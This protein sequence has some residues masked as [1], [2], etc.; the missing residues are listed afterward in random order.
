MKSGLAI[1]SMGLALQAAAWTPNVAERNAGIKA[2]DLTPYFGRLTAWL[3]AKIAS[4]PAAI[5]AA[6]LRALLK[7]PAFVSALSERHFMTKIWGS[8][9]GL[10][11]PLNAF[12]QADP[13]NKTFVAALMASGELMDAVMLARTPSAMF[14]RID[15]SHSLNAADLE[16]WKQIS[17]AYPESRKGLYQRLAIATMLRPPGTGNRGAGMAATPETPEARYLHFRDAH[18]HG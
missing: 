5:N 7:D 3:D 12:L 11:G 1:L 6:D 14:A 2:G 16:H 18:Q 4:D 15:D 10:L 8:E 9:K 13:K 17:F